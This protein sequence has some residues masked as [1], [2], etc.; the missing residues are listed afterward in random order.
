MSTHD[1]RVH[2]R[3]GWAPFR[4]F[5]ERS[6][7]G[8]LIVVAVGLGFGL[9]LL[10]VRV[11]W[12]PLQRL[13]RG[14]ADGLNGLVAPHPPVVTVLQAIADFGGRPFMLWLVTIAVVLLL[15]RRRTRL[16][17]YLVVTGVGALLLDPSLKT[18]VGRLR[19]VV[20]VQVATAPGNSFPSGHALGSMVAYGALLLVFLPAVAPRWRKA[21][22]GLVAAIIVAIG[23]TRIALGVHF[24]SDVLGGWLLGAAWLSVTA[25]AFRVWR[26]EA[27]RPVGTLEAG[28]EPEAA[29]DVSPAPDEKRI[30]PHPWAG[31]A[32]L[33]VGWVLTFGVLYVLGWAVTN[34][35][36]GTWIR[37]VDNGVPRW[38][39]TLRTPAL[40]HL[41][42]LG[43]KAGD[44]HMI[45]TVSLIFCP[46]ALALWRRWRPVL[47]VVLAMLGEL[48]LFLASAAAVDRPRP[49]VEHLDGQLPTSAFPS[50][51]IAATM[52]L[53]TAIA[54]LVVP[55]VRA[56]WR[57]I[58]VALAVIMPAGVA[59]SRMY[60][61][62]HHPSDVLGAAVL[63]ACWLTL[64]WFVVRPNADAARGN[65][66]DTGE[67]AESDAHRLTEAP[68]AVR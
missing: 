8:L 30:L 45:L 66:A 51:H 15:I 3:V 9:L 54:L 11:H 35:A 42:Y 7:L 29:H 49:P 65:R 68:Q 60:R 64:L 32:E 48:S 12:T 5:T 23:V 63:T 21:A 4:H 1:G 34:P 50:G 41:S 39:Q 19:P 55:R 67:L 18:L 13:D 61:G 52:C 25:Y 62:M 16:A 26:R 22:I 28:L 33:I 31:A 53:Y 57:W 6:I 44:T 59:V 2:Q 43:S 40:D 24:L 27:G 47:F 37:S 14:V 38:L 56:W 58:F 46:L 10:L 36:G 20:D 17:V